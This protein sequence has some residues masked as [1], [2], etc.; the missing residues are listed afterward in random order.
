M[1]MASAV[2]DQQGL[3]Q[4]DAEP[5]FLVRWLR[6]R[7]SERLLGAVFRWSRLCMRECN[8]RIK[9]NRIFDL[10]PESR[11]QRAVGFSHSDE[12]NAE[13]CNFN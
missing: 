7:F 11:T 8:N 3:V 1:P 13:T 2:W 5:I 6:P 9:Q 12:T 4:Q 10:L